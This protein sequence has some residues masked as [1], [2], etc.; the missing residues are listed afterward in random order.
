[1]EIGINLIFHSL[2]LISKAKPRRQQLRGHQLSDKGGYLISSAS[3]TARSIRRDL[4]RA[5]KG[6]AIE[7]RRFPVS[8][9]HL[10]CAIPHHPS[11]SKRGYLKA[12]AQRSLSNTNSWSR[13][14]HKAFA[15]HGTVL[16]TD[17]QNQT[18][19][20]ICNSFAELHGDNFLYRPT[21]GI[22]CLAG[23]YELHLET[24]T[25]CLCRENVFLAV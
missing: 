14:W 2:V 17:K 13:Y 3:D 16:L 23:R 4:T 8:Q 22:L 1:M 21:S 12:A 6:A 25:E 18:G 7:L 20:S 9:G 24:I 19:M 5:N 15:S 11:P 10:N